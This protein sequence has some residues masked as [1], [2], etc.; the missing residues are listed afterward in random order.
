MA[1]KSPGRP[2]RSH[3]LRKPLLPMSRQLASKP[4]RLRELPHARELLPALAADCRAGRLALFLDFDG[5][6]APIAAHPRLARLDAGLRRVLAELAARVPVAV[7]SGRAAS[8]VRRL[9]GIDE[10]FVAGSHGF[11]IAGPGGL[12]HD[13]GA[14]FAAELD[15]A[16]AELERAVRGLPG[17]WVERKPYAIAVHFRD[18]PEAVAARIEEPVREVARARPALLL[19]GGK[20]VFEL[21]P[22]KDWDKGRAVLWLLDRVA[23]REARAVFLGDDVTDEDAFLRLRECGIGIVV[24]EEERP[25]F[26]GYRLRDTR[27]VRAFLTALLEGCRERRPEAASGP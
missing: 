2:G 15:A 18:A 17:V 24:G 27:E 23:P 3:L 5:T 13:E 4:H 8:D 9:V 10:I 6:L 19:R 12:A 20:K 16:Q 14:P 7:V 26:A 11:E 1:L 21:R 22:A 25:T